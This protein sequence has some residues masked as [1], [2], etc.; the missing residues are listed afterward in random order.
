VK[1]LIDYLVKT[2]PKLRISLIMLIVTDHL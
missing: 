1:F 2:V